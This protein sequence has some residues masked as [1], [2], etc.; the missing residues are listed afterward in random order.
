MS[1]MDNLVRLANLLS[2]SSALM[3][4]FVNTANEVV[5]MLNKIGKLQAVEVTRDIDGYVA[6]LEGSNGKLRVKV[7]IE[8]EE[9]VGKESG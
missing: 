2:R 5:T 4:F 1:S 3:Q 8:V 7:I 6:V 9:A